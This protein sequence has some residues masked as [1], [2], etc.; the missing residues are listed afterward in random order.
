MRTYTSGSKNPLLLIREAK[1]LYRIHAEHLDGKVA[2]FIRKM[3]RFEDKVNQRAGMSLENCDILIIGPGQ[4]A[5]ELTY[6]SM[7]NRVVGIDLDVILDSNNPFAYLKMLRQNGLMRTVKTAV[8][9]LLGVDRRGAQELRRQLNVEK[10]QRPQLIQMDAAQMT[11]PDNHFDL[12]YTFSVFEHLPDPIAV[13]EQVKRVLR[14][15]G[16]AYISLHLYTNDSGSHDPRIWTNSPDQPPLWAHLRPE[17][18]AKVQSNAYLNQWRIEQWQKC[19]QENLPGAGLEYETH[20]GAHHT[21]LQGELQSLRQQN[22][23]SDF[24]DEELLTVN[25]TAF[26]NKPA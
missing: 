13:I 23:L 3:R 5:G 9:K 8:R 1:D 10:S 18:K 21:K 16:V 6:F 14:P 20:E 15:G 2:D 12:I 11:F 17:H 24:T 25:F 19:F 26:W 4:G 22:E 7:K